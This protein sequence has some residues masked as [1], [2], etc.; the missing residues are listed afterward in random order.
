MKY[1][2]KY[3]III[4]LFITIGLFFYSCTT[5]ENVN[6]VSTNTRFKSLR[7]MILVKSSTSLLT[8]QFAGIGV[9]KI[10]VKKEEGFLSRFGEQDTEVTFEEL[11]PFY[12]ENELINISDY[13]FVISGN[14]FVL[15]ND[16]TYFLS[17]ED[18]QLYL[19]T[20]NEKL[21]IAVDYDYVFE[22]ESSLLI[23]ALNELTSTESKAHFDGGVFPA[24]CGFF[25]S[26]EV[27]SLGFTS[28]SS[29]MN[30]YNATHGAGALGAGCRSMGPASTSC[31]FDNHV[32]ATTRSFC[33]D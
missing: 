14:K 29:Q 15:G 17:V 7:D 21:N 32:C 23:L 20:P 31:L 28:Y 5:D 6:E 24:S 4:V 22:K 11:K 12:I 3:S 9:S 33:C 25:D 26:Y 27:V 2:F 10:N 8:K 13:T 16:Y 30:S 19:N 1:N 18:G